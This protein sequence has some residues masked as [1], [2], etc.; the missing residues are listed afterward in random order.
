MVSLCCAALVETTYM[1]APGVCQGSFETEST[2]CFCNGVG[3]DIASCDTRNW[4][5]IRPVFCDATR[6]MVFD[7]GLEIWQI[8]CLPSIASHVRRSSQKRP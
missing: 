3:L 4:L 8:V 1:G 6:R 5:V 2:A 7:W